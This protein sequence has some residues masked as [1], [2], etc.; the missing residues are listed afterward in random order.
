MKKRIGLVLCGGTI[1]SVSSPEG[2]VQA[3][4]AQDFLKYVPELQGLADFQ[5][6]VFENIDSSQANP[7]VWARL[8]RHIQKVRLQCDAV[9]VTHGTDTMAESATA[10]SFVFADIL[11]GPI[12]FTG[13]QLPMSSP[14]SDGQNN[15]IGAFKVALKALNEGVTE[16]MVYFNHKVFRGNRMWKKSEDD[17]DAFTSG[18]FPLLAY[19]T[20]SPL[21]DMDKLDWD[22]P[23]FHPLA[24]RRKQTL[25]LSGPKF[26]FGKGVVV[27]DLYPGTPP[28]FWL[29]GIAGGHC[30]GLIFKTMGAGNIPWEHPQYDM[31]PVIKVARSKDIPVLV[32]LKFPGGMA[33]SSP[34]YKAGRVALIEGAIP[35][36]DLV[37]EAAYVKLLYLLGLGCHT[38]AQVEKMMLKSMAGE[39]TEY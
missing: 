16:V 5:V 24:I 27:A 7:N 30:T 13:S 36:G 8:A 39:V 26:H 17:F 10:M 3:E 31:R 25:A 14:M 4:N 38:P 37:H 15:L 35:T 11:A 34:V 29:S 33:R 32:T 22:T 12:V 20:A 1:N 28:G 18:N 2:N 6:Y 9:I 19:V 23:V 21:W